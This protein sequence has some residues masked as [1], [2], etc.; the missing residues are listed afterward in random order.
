MGATFP[1]LAQ[2]A[3]K[4]GI[5]G[6]YA[7][8]LFGACLGTLTGAFLLLGTIG[9]SGSHWA[10]VALSAATGA[11]ALRLAAGEDAAPAAP[12]QTKPNDDRWSWPALAVFAS[13]LAGMAFEVVWIR[14]LVPAFNNSAYGFAA[15]LV[16]FLA[17]LGGGSWLSARVRKP[18]LGLL[19]ALL[20]LS[21]LSGF[22]GYLG[23]ELA[24][25]LMSRYAD[26]TNSGIVP[27]LLAPL[28]EALALLAP[29]ALLQGALLPLAI[30][31][32]VKEDG[33][34][35]AVG[36]LYAFNTVGAIFGALAAGFWWIPHWNVQN[37]LLISVGI[38]LAAGSAL[39]WASLP[40]KTRWLAPLGAAA[41]LALAVGRLS[42]RYLPAEMMMEWTTRFPA[43]APKL[44]SYREDIEG[45]VAVQSRG[46]ARFL[47]INGVGVTGYNNATKMIAHI[48]ML[49]HPKPERA[50][51]I[52]FGMGTTFRSA[53]RHPA[54]VDAVEL[55]GSVVA[56][57][58]LFYPDADYWR[59]HP[60]ARVSIN[61][62]RNHL[63]RDKE[64][65]DVIMVDPSPPLYAAG[66]VNLYSRDFFALG[67][68]K[69]KTGG[70]MAVWLP[71]YAET[72]FKMVMKSFTA[73]F[74]HTQFWLGTRP[75]NGFIML[76]SDTPITLDRR[77]M[78]K[79]LAE[80]ELRKDLLELNY[81]FKDKAA[82]WSLYMGPGSRFTDYLAD[83]A[84]VTDDLPT[85]EYPLLRAR[86][87]KKYFNHPAALA[88]PPVAVP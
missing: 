16:I 86:D 12:A 76:G 74:P 4:Q 5:G 32:D 21:G 13:G 34:G 30:R 87:R 33:L 54:R 9:L 39:L 56:N 79:R 45:S 17:G 52:C 3:D 75:H 38:C 55:V 47:I 19:G 84:E 7:A 64:G 31:L 73:A 18:T 81:E 69:L 29:L 59:A 65:Y 70:L 40:A 36:K 50:L 78:E 68:R 85:I 57:F 35:G 15:V 42:G 67:R 26:M 71:E 6:L 48:P 2:A 25:V 88:W 41:L 43:L 51:I 62:G 61:D 58:P 72:E 63:L 10:A 22:V 14:L 83:A 37:A 53:L 23:F 46:G 8:N 60:K 28:A 20:A 11:L 27:L 66:T 49:I 44:I 77:A 1:V 24:E 80:P 82:F